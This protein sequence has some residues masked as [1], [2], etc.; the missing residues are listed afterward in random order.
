MC[1]RYANY[2][3]HDA[4]VKAFGI[5]QLEGLCGPSWNVA[6]TQTVSIVVDDAAPHP[7]DNPSPASGS[8]LARTARWGLLP[9]WVN[10]PKAFPLLIN[11]RS[12]TVTSK[13]AFRTAAARRRALVVA[14]GYYEWRVEGDG[15]KQ[16]YYL[17]PTAGDPLGFAGLYEWWRA[18][19]SGGNQRSQQTQEHLKDQVEHWICT[20]TII[21]RS[22]AD[23]L[24]YVH[25]RMPV[26]VPPDAIS[27][28]LD[29]D[30]TDRAGVEGLLRAMP[31]P[32]L[33][34]RRVSK[35]VNS[36]RHDSPELIEPLTGP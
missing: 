28:W 32:N 17:A 9:A 8:R 18:P 12:E 33:V 36:V 21:T 26:V 4:V 13:P 29:P 15:S 30:M 35:A 7:P 5:D 27:A 2:H 1:G 31:A 16:P 25:D 22:A 24:G 3:A 14:S 11:A 34:P 23:S 19:S 6:P 20:V 10:D